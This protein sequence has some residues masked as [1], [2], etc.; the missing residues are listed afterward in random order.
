VTP[1]KGIF[2]LVVR[3]RA[4]TSQHNPY[5]SRKDETEN[6]CDCGE[7]DYEDLTL[8]LEQK[9]PEKI[10]MVVQAKKPRK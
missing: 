6:M 7:Y 3:R 10:P 4:W 1:D 9:E 8:E 5:H 2:S